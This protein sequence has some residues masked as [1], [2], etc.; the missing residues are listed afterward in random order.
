MT[1][2]S[3]YTV[4]SDAATAEEIARI[5]AIADAQAGAARN[6][7]TGGLAGLAL[8]L[9]IVFG[10]IFV[11]DL[12][13]GI[14]ERGHWIVLVMGSTIMVVPMLLIHL[15]SAREGQADRN[16]FARSLRLQ[17]ATGKVLRHR[18]RRDA[19]H[20]FVEHEH[21]VMHLSPADG[22]RTLFLDFSSVGD[23]P[24][25]EEWYAK[26][27]ID[28]AEWRWT[29]TPDG[30]ALLDFTADGAALTPRRLLDAQGRSDDAAA[31]DAFESLGSPRDGALLR[32]PF[33]DIEASLG[34][35]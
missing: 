17:A 19:A 11:L 18:L 20:L 21:G 1:D 10:V 34:A 24:R 14:I 6:A 27:R 22:G 2:A 33:A 31:A 9:A 32:R 29:T 5:E 16:A 7:V 26:G 28:R 30:E 4:E 8:V 35:R 15:R 13:F 23:D 25:W 3:A 12:A